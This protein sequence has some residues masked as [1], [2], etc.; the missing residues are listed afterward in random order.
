MHANETG[1]CVIA[2]GF[3]NGYFAVGLAVSHA[4]LDLVH[5]LRFGQS[6]I[7]QA[8]ELRSV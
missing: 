6:G 2:I 1:T 3:A 4:C 5:E 7:F 8:S